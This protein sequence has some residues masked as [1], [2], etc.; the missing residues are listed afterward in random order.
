MQL[1]VNGEV[2]CLEGDDRL[3]TLLR[4]QGVNDRRVAL[5][6]NSRVLSM[7]DAAEYRLCENDRIDILTLA[8]GG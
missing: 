6:V 8:G 3:T 7:A 1:T 5:V 4:E 2:C